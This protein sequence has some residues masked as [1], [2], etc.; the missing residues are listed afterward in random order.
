MVEIEIIH[1]QPFTENH[2]HFLIA[3]QSISSKALFQSP[4]QMVCC[5]LAY[6][7]C[8]LINT[9]LLVYE[10]SLNM[11]HIL[12]VCTWLQ[13]PVTAAIVKCYMLNIMLFN[14]HTHIFIPL[15]QSLQVICNW[16]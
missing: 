6:S 1:L 16:I 12:K 5:T 9:E 7:M 2:F 8:T 3:V 4:K 11:P 14:I 15:I 13:M 10:T